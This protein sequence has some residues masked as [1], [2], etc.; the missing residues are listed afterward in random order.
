MTSFPLKPD[1]KRIWRDLETLASFH[2]PNSEGWTRRSFTPAYRKGREYIEERMTQAGL[3]VSRDAAANLIGKRAGRNPRLP[4]IWV[5]SHTDTVRNGGRFDGTVGVIAAIEIARVLRENRHDLEHTLE[6]I[7]YTAEEP[8]EFGISTVGSKALAGNLSK[9]ML[10][11]TDGRGRTLGEAIR[12]YG[13]DPDTLLQAARSRGSVAICLEL[14]IEQGPVLEAAGDILG[15]VSGIV[16]IRRFRLTVHGRADHAGTTPMTRRHDALTG[17]AEMILALERIGSSCRDPESCVATVGRIAISPNAANV[18]PGSAELNAE[19]RTL[20][21]RLLEDLSSRFISTCREIAAKRKLSL[22]LSTLSH[23]DPVRVEPGILQL[24]KQA[25]AGV[26]DHCR[27]ITSGAGHDSNH[28][29]CL[30]PVGMIFVPSREGRSHCPEEYTD[31]RSI[32]IGTEAL[33]YAVLEID[34]RGPAQ[35]AN[36]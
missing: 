35:E 21:G 10:A 19:I 18:I 11:L 36:K 7:D 26:T 13:G 16:G 5:G 1:P 9:A 4:P 34:K 6:I 20:D 8:T 23:T 25:C 30:A 2:E 24:I 31:P 14:H 15:A 3:T 12:E 27:E 17:S 29:A 22:E 28:L 33:L 32:A